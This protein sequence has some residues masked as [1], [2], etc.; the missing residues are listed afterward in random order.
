MESFKLG[1]FGCVSTVAAKWHR[2]LCR[3]PERASSQQLRRVR[4]NLHPSGSR[5][6]AHLRVNWEQQLPMEA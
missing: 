6:S 3:H 4:N 1:R 2:Y 5:N